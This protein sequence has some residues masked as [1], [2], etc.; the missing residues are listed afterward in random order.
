MLEKNY[1]SLN[2]FHR[3]RHSI[4]SL[5]HR[6]LIILIY[7]LSRLR[8][9]QGVEKGKEKLDVWTAQFRH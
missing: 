9:T 2:I 8:Y 6:T 5:S 1:Y 4:R 3:K 7:G